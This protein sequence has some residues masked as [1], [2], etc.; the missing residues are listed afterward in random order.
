MT[1]HGTPRCDEQT[2]AHVHE[3][4]KIMW[5]PLLVLVAGSFLAGAL[6][7]GVFVGDSYEEFWK[8]AIFILPTHTA[9]EDAHHVPFWVK[10]SPLVVGLLG[11]GSAWYIYLK[12]P[13][14]AARI[15][16]AVPALYR[17]SLNKWYFDELYDRVFVRSARWFGQGFWK[18]D[19][20]VIDGVGPDGVA[21]MTNRFARMMSA[22][23]S[24]YVYHYAFAMLI[25]VVCLISWYLLFGS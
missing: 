15:A 24:G 7:Y 8:E 4:P 21:A 2:L 18:T 11:I 10:A 12:A 23:Q 14:S 1:F 16:G 25:G 20:E 22:I 9:L 19:G 3:S 5:V 13:G 6:G 17:F